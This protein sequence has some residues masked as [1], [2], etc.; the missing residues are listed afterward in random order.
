MSTLTYS[1]AY[2]EVMALA[3]AAFDA[4]PI[5]SVHYPDMEFTIPAGDTAWARIAYDLISAGPA[6]MADATGRKRFRR[7]GLLSIQLFHPLGGGSTD[8]WNAAKVVADAFEGQTTAGGVWFR[9]LTG[10]SPIGA[11]GGF[12]QTNLAV[13]FEY[14]EVK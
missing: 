5:T 6:S 12:S 1:D 14:D 10:P 11:S 8:A 4:V 13:A 3:K 9:D 2:D 7:S